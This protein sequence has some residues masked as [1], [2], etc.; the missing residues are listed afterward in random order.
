MHQD[1]AGYPI[2]RSFCEGRDN[3][4]LDRDYHGS[5]LSL[6]QIAPTLTEA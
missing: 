3:T 1:M 6:R 5:G 2:L 4:N